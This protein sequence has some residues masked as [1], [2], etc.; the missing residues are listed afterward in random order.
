MR[1]LVTGS[2][3][4]VAQ[5][6]KDY[7]ADD[8][9][10]EFV[11]LDRDEAP[12][13]DHVADIQNYDAIRPAFDGVDAVVHLAAYPRTD[14][15]WEEILDNSIVGMRNVLEAASDA[16]VRTFVFASSIHAAGMWEVNNEPDIYDL[17]S[18][19][20]V[21]VDDWERP[22]SF[23][24]VSKAFGEDIGRYYVENYDAP[25]QF[26]ALRIASTRDAPYDH[27][28]GDAERGVDRGE[29]ERGSAEY[30]T[31]VKRMKGTWLSQRD[32]AQLVERCLEDDDVAFDAFFA[33]SDND[34]AWYDIEH[35][36][37]VLGYEPNDRAEDWQAPPRDRLD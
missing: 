36:K 4:Q 8:S 28:Y 5:G 3:G 6:I 13:V 25:E 9:D 7:L 34:R 24:G 15:T 22:D 33:T 19:I 18:D 11:Y 29:W 32:L 23:Y 17:N 20:T 30:V 16:D 37:E 27:P 31:E 2:N 26:Y 10:D 14:G 21:T 1:V 12:D 35:T